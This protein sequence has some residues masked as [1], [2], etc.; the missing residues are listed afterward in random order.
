MVKR[1]EV[2]RTLADHEKR[3]VRLE[4]LLYK[5]KSQQKTSRRNSLAQHILS[6]RDSGFFAQPRT[7]KEVHKKLLPSYH[8]E[9]DRVVMALYR[10]ALRKQ[11]RKASKSINGRPYQAY[12]W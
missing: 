11:L 1:D 9:L 2:T 8:C 5:P 3:L 6:L 4:T 10:V 12:V 7:A